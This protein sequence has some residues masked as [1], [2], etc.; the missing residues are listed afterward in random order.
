MIAHPIGYILFFCTV[1]CIAGLDSKNKKKIRNDRDGLL[2]NKRAGLLNIANVVIS[3]IGIYNI[4]LS[5]LTVIALTV[6]WL[7]PPEIK[8]V[9]GRRY[10]LI[11]F[12]ILV[13]KRLIDFI[14]FLKAKKL[15][16]KIK[17]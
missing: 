9:V 7:S 15:K 1:F 5:V 6:C 8:T 3:K 10:G 17:V 11:L 13:I 2:D 14:I 16:F 4:I 12:V